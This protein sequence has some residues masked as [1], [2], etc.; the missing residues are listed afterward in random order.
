MAS[1]VS[2]LVLL[3]SNGQDYWRYP[4]IVGFF[5]GIWALWMRF[6]DKEGIRPIDECF[7]LSYK[8]ILFRLQS[9]PKLVLSLIPIYGFSYLTYSV[10]LVFLNPFLN[11]TTEFPL[12]TLLEQTNYLFWLDA[13]L[14]PLVALLLNRLDWVMSL[15]GSILIFTLAA[16]MLF[17]LLPHH[18]VTTLFILRILLVIGGIGFSAALIPWTNKLLPPSDKYLFHSLSYNL[19]SELFGRSTPFMCFWMY[20]MLENPASPLIYILGLCGLTLGLIIILQM[21][22]RSLRSVL[23]Y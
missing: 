10:P 9:N 21:D 13:L 8:G 16:V 23:R 18:S 19:G 6:H 7:S 20:A 11:Q 4:F 3:S 14:F 5:L 17:L 22:N 2:S 1:S 15:I 12:S